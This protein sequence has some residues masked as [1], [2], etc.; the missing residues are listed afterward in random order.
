MLTAANSKCLIIVSPFSFFSRLTME[1]ACGFVYVPPLPVNPNHESNAFKRSGA[2]FNFL[3]LLKYNILYILLLSF[4]E[5]QRSSCERGSC[6]CS[7]PTVFLLGE[8][9]RVMQPVTQSRPSSETFFAKSFGS[10]KAIW[11][12]SHIFLAA[13]R[14]TQHTA[15]CDWLQRCAENAKRQIHV[16]I[17]VFP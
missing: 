1:F 4:F 14:S 8:A 6:C 15:C 10:L 9:L 17:H 3:L 7:P 16:C 5:A 12:P 11:Q 13:Q 2:V